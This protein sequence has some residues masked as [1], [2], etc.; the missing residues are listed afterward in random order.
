LLNVGWVIARLTA[1]CLFSLSFSA[2]EPKLYVGML[3][4]KTTEDSMRKLFEP[5]GNVKEVH[6]MLNADNTSKGAPRACSAG[7]V[8]VFGLLRAPSRTCSSP[9]ISSL[10]LA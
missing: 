4:R 3:S 2:G 6:L 5:Y 9:S 7:R 1:D 8:S 10:A